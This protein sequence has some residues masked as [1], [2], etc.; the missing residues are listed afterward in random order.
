[1]TTQPFVFRFRIELLGLTSPIWRLIEV[2]M[3]YTFWDLHVAIQDVMG[4]LDYHL[5]VFQ[6]V[7]L[8]GEIGIPDKEGIS[9]VEIK[10]GWEVPIKGVFSEIRPLASYQYD[11]GDSWVHEVRFEGF[12][13]ADKD[14]K[15]PR[16][17]DGARRCPPEDSGGPYFYPEFLKAIADSSHPEHDSFLE[18]V[19]GSFDPEDFDPGKVEF[20]DPEERRR[21]AF[22]EE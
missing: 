3:E 19:G 8:Q 22:E 21:I 7:G 15:Y 9:S 17:L 12:K 4:W 5:H 11:F 20:D 18:R 2:P 13:E 16:C 1:M 6:V 14:V 10:A